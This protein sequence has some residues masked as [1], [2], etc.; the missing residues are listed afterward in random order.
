VANGVANASP[1]FKVTGALDV[2]SPGA[3][4]PE[5]ASSVT[6]T[7][8]WDDDSSEKAYDLMVL[9]AFGAIVWQTSIPGVTGSPTVSVTYGGP[10]LQSGMY[11][12]FRAISRDA[13]SNA[14]SQTEDLKGV[15][16]LP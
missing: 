7:F 3:N 13:A 1:S 11:Y 6:P 10:A 12:Q 5:Q 15:F 8:T 2:V 16:Y 4:G 9:D 14:L